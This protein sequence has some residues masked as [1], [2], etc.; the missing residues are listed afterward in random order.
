[1]T[2]SCNKILPKLS[3]VVPAVTL[4]RISVHGTDN[5][6]ITGGHI[7]IRA[8]N[9]GRAVDLAP[10]LG[11]KLVSAGLPEAGCRF[12]VEGNQGRL[13]NL[14]DGSGILQIDYSAN[15]F[16][17]PGHSGRLAQVKIED[18]L[19]CRSTNNEIVDNRL[20]GVLKIRVGRR[21]RYTI[22]SSSTAGHGIYFDF[23]GYQGKDIFMVVG[24]DEV[25]FYSDEE[26]LVSCAREALRDSIINPFRMADFKLV[27][28]SEEKLPIS[29]G[30]YVNYPGTDITIYL[31]ENMREC[32]RL[33]YHQRVF[34]A[35]EIIE[36]EAPEYFAVMKSEVRSIVQYTGGDKN[37]AG[38]ADA[39]ERIISLNCDDESI[40]FIAGV[41]VHEALHIAYFNGE[42]AHLNQKGN[43]PVYAK[44]NI[45]YGHKE[46]VDIGNLLSET[47]SYIE[48]MIFSLRAFD[49]VYSFVYLMRV[50]Q[51]LRLLHKKN[52]KKNDRLTPAGRRFLEYLDARMGLLIKRIAPR[53]NELF[54]ERSIGRREKIV[55]KEIVRRRGS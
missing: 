20:E 54:N 47:E 53:L 18:I 35:L 25:M 14:Q 2:V 44:K 42:G 34:R 9:G 45:Y 8:K 31:P 12:Q 51:G 11:I 38:E 30:R 17:E 39:E 3:E 4:R 6:F 43:I 49:R 22:R 33:A 7:D 16:C 27:D 23:P 50:D 36:R 10:L 29:Y 32:D 24:H 1:M 55:I 21:E 37:T 15:S 19:C 41:L 13:V 52:D 46:I 26:L 48:D 28:H 5:G 40:E